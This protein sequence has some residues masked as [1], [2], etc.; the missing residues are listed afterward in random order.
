MKSRHA[1]ALALVGWYLII[2]PIGRNGM[3]AHE[4]MEHWLIAGQF[5][6]KGGC[7][8]AAREMRA[9]GFDSSLI[10]RGVTVGS[11]YVND[12]WAQKEQAVC[13][14]FAPKPR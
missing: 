12:E 1:A 7:E 8:Q 10:A 11:K 4:A 14:S 2:P 13:V 9:D 5:W 6:T 3:I